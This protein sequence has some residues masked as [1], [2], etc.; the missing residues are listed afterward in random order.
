MQFSA[1]FLTIAMASAAA[2]PAA[3]GGSQSSPLCPGLGGTPQC[4]GTSVLGVAA[5]SCEDREFFTSSTTIITTY[6]PTDGRW[7]MVM[8]SPFVLT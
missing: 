3:L 8:M 2:L 6:Y 1:I 5:L 7:S 4:C